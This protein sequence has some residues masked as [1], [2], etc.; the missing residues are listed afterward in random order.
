MIFQRDWR[1]IIRD[2]WKLGVILLQ[3][4]MKI[5]LLGVFFLNEMPSVGDVSTSPLPNLTFFPAQSACFN[6]IAGNIIP[7]IISV[8]LTSTPPLSQY[9][10]NE[11]STIRKQIPRNT[12]L[13]LTTSVR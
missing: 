10:P 1:N 9:L 2:G 3:V 7:A 5:L 11:N 6:N 8:A 4:V 12:S 13:C